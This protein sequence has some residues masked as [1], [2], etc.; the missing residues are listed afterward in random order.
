MCVLLSPVRIF[1]FVP[2]P[3]YIL[4]SCLI[5]NSRDLSPKTL[6][7][8]PRWQPTTTVGLYN[9]VIGHGVKGKDISIPIIFVDGIFQHY[10]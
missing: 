7:L 6:S 1:L 8:G 2:K 5:T 3:T 10:S 9:E 4:I